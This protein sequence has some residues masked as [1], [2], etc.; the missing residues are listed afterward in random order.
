MSVY[1]KSKLLKSHRVEKGFSREKLSEGICDITTLKRY[2]NEGMLPSEDN[3]RLLQE[4]MGG[5]PEQI[6]MSYD[7]GL[8]V[9]GDRYV[10]YENLLNNQKYDEL[11][12]KMQILKEGLKNVESVEKEQ[13]LARL[14]TL[15]YYDYTKEMLEI[16]EGLLK[17]SVPDYKDGE[18]S[19][20]RLYN[21]TEL[22]LLNDIAITNDKIGCT[23]MAVK[24]FEKL[25]VYL[26]Q[27]E[28]NKDSMIAV[29]IYFNYANTLGLSGQYEKSIEICKKGIALEKK[30]SCQ[31]LL[32]ALV[33]NIGWLYDQ[34]WMD[35]HDEKYKKAAKEYVGL[36]LALAKYFDE[37]PINTPTIEGYY[38][39]NFT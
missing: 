4:K 17:K 23:E 33:F 28:D 14:E 6:I 10:E 12:M 36:S 7:M 21:D 34:I 30:N 29:K 1:K 15:T 32:Y 3:Y 8:F 38:K 35:N 9:D 2:E 24:I 25:D 37:S 18:F 16:Q 13:F 26:E 31:E 5:R 20:T 39:E 19:I 22:N 11:R 27:A